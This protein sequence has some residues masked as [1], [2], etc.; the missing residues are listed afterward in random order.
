MPEDPILE[1]LST[2]HTLTSASS[3]MQKALDM[4]VSDSIGEN[5]EI[6]VNGA[7]AC[8]SL[9]NLQSSLIVA[10]LE[11]NQKI[12]EKIQEFIQITRESL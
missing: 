7:A 11:E 4:L 12:T 10:L 3:E 2:I 1:L 5:I 8:S 6:S 9:L